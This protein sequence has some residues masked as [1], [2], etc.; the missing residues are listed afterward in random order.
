MNNAKCDHTNNQIMDAG[1]DLRKVFKIEKALLSQDQASPLPPCDSVAQ[2]TEQFSDYFIGKIDKIR[3]DLHEML[4]SSY[5]CGVQFIDPELSCDNSLSSFKELSLIELKNLISKSPTKSCTL[6]PIPT[7]ILKSC[8][9]ELSPVILDLGNR[10]LSTGT[11][12]KG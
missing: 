11:F 8:F 10:S 2:L 12:P 9:D 5:E 6:D 4:E 3:N 1:S 7:T